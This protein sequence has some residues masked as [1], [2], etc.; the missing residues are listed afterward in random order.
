VESNP[1]TGE[2][3]GAHF[4]EVAKRAEPKAGTALKSYFAF[5]TFVGI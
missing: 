5:G 4:R 3:K 1:K 2:L